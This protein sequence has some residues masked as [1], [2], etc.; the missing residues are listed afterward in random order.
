METLNFI[1]TNYKL[2]CL[3]LAI[4]GF[5]SI[6]IVFATTNKIIL[7]PELIPYSM[8]YKNVRAVLSAEDWQAIARIK[9]KESNYK[10]D[11]CGAKGRLECHEVWKFNDKSLVQSLIGLTSLCPDC[12]R[13]KHIGLARKMGWFGD[14]LYH[15]AK[16][17]NI[18]KGKA[19]RL[20]E[21]AEE[22]VKTRREEYDLDLTY[23]NQYGNLLP[24]KY[25]TKE[26]NNCV[27]MK[28]N[29]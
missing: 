9:Y 29:Y 16:V 2:I 28:D 18:S 1:T 7:A 6:Y 20:I 26:N 3:V 22:Q 15:M 19:K 27:Q 12:H 17:N 14:A 11:I 5:I 4:L 10:C 21:I 13:V 24:R 25:T 8:H 23:L